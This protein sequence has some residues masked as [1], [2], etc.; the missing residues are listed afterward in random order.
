MTG[1]SAAHS[2][3][4]PAAKYREYD[5]LRR[6]P[7]DNKP[8]SQP[9]IPPANP[10][11]DVHESP[12]R[13]VQQPAATPQKTGTRLPAPS[14][15]VQV[16]ETRILEGEEEATVEPTPAAIRI[17]LGPTP[18]R[19]GQIL[20]L[21]D[22]T[23]A[24]TPSRNRSALVNGQ[25]NTTTTTPS[26]A[27]PD[28]TTIAQSPASN[29]DRASRT[30]ASSGKRFLLDTFATPLKR[31]R[32]DDDEGTGTPSSS[33]KAFATPAFLRRSNTISIMETLAEEAEHDD[34]FYGTAGARAPPFK[35]KRGFVR[36]LSSIIQGMRNQEDDRLDEEMEL[37]REMEGE[38]EGFANVESLSTSKKR[39]A[40]LAVPVDDSQVAMPLGPDRG[41]DS[42][43]E[44]DEQLDDQ[45]GQPRKPWK[46]KGL[47][48]QTKRVISK[49]SCTTILVPST[50]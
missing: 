1:S 31:K 4:I 10:A 33:M 29:I 26:K 22:S 27:R 42:S 11:R 28:H 8:N 19:D 35:G 6:P 39:A 17:Q 38:T 43:E 7:S 13:P 12:V 50:R 49:C 36:S 46:K 47:K 18:Q 15:P 34:D 5:R 48:R 23:P 20:S 9:T 14:I 40:N 32:E 30:P 24:E 3:V 44:E 16:P 2:C 21:F 25:R 45:N 37:M 41:S